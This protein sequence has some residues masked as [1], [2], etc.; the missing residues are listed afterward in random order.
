MTCFS[1]KNV[2][3]ESFKFLRLSSVYK[4][5]CFVYKLEFFA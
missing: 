5:E 4:K 3:L 2:L 1:A